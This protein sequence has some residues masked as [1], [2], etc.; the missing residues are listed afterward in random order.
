MQSQI[1][2]VDDWQLDFD[3][4][5]TEDAY[6]LSLSNSN[7]DDDNYYIDFSQYV[8]M[9][10]AS[11]DESYLDVAVD[12]FENKVSQSS[13]M[14][15][16]YYGWL[17]DAD[18]SGGGITNGGGGNDGQEIPLSQ[19]RGFG[20]TAAHMLWVLSTATEYLSKNDN[21]AQFDTNYLWFKTNICE[22]WRSRDLANI[23][24][25]RTHIMS[26]WAQIGFYM[27]KIESNANYRKWYDD[28][29]TDISDG[30]Y[31][32][33]MREQ[34]RIVSLVGGDGYVWSGEW[35]VTTNVNDVSHANAEVELMV[36]GAE[37]S[38][39]WSLT[40]MSRLINTFDENVYRSSTQGW[41]YMDGTSV[42]LNVQLWEQG[43]IKLGRFDYNLQLKLNDIVFNTHSQKYKKRGLS[44]M[45][46][47]KAYL[48]GVVYPLEYTSPE[49][50][51]ST[52]TKNQKLIYWRY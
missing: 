2:T 27:D 11:G 39:Y 28:F 30:V 37:S 15:D 8:S 16:G 35:G 36:A 7:D 22:K 9:Y 13:L 14:V 34:L 5:T 29:N 17:R 20:R 31:E 41:E 52:S 3:S 1:K 10:Q 40:D 45:A 47:N 50:E 19:T 42:S 23:Y 24:R 51:P 18:N 26:H 12:L 48:D 43:W 25:I 21:Q 6:Y 33:S 44:E 38:D 49:T 4:E 32:G 46:Y